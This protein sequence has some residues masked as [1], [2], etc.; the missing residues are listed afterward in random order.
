MSVVSLVSL[1]L[2]ACAPVVT[3]NAPAAQPAEAGISQPVI[4]GG[5]V[6]LSSILL[7]LARNTSTVST[8]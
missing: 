6:V 2:S 7:L 3:R 5:A 4:I 8:R 1:S